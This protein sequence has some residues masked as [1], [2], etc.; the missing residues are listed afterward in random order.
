MHQFG[1]LILP[2]VHE[3]ARIITRI[4]GEENGREFVSRHTSSERTH[5]RLKHSSELADK[6][7]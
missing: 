5:A 1:Q 2:A 4:Q 3:W 7:E 6:V